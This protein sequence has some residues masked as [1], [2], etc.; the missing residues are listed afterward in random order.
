VIRTL[1]QRPLTVILA[2]ALIA[3]L[4][5]GPEGLHRVA[6]WAFISMRLAFA[7]AAAAAHYDV[8]L[9]TGDSR[10]TELG[11]RTSTRPGSLVVN[12]GLS[13]STSQ[14]WLAYFD[15]SW[16]G[17]PTNSTVVLWVGINDLLFTGATARTV[18]E[19]VRQ[20]AQSLTARG[21][22]V[23]LLDQVAAVIAPHQDIL[24]RLDT[25]SQAVNAT[26][27]VSPPAGVRRVPVADLLRPTTD[28]ATTPALFD[29]IHLSPAANDQIWQRIDHVLNRPA[30]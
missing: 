16:I 9:L 15:N 5:I 11:R 14:D 1:R 12:I 6:P 19:R 25:A 28:P 26:L 30:N 7:K 17:R 29:G 2:G 22:R 13:G 3:A 21:N 24:R 27:D 18:A 8:I 10:M 4:A 20:L 23:L